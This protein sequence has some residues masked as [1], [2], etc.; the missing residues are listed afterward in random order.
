MVGPR[1]VSQMIGPESRFIRAV[2]GWMEGIRQH[3]ATTFEHFLRYV[4]VRYVV[5]CWLALVLGLCSVSMPILHHG[6]VEPKDPHCRS[7]FSRYSR[8]LCLLCSSFDVP[9]SSAT[10][11][12]LV[13]VFARTPRSRHVHVPQ[14]VFMH[15]VHCSLDEPLR[16]FS[17]RKRFLASFTCVL[18]LR[19]RNKNIE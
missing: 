15:I 18:K 5:A 4:V 14:W 7:A 13:C 10:G 9:P 16:Q 1:I 2:I 17:S 3:S 6:F 19:P 11:E 8:F 12:T